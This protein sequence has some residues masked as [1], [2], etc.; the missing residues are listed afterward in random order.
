MW[1]DRNMV[2]GF[3][4]LSTCYGI[5]HEQPFFSVCVIGI[6]PVVV[7]EHVIGEKITRLF[8]VKCR[9]FR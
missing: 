3:N 7:W 8:S 5:V 2:G 4:R 6:V 9:R 1:N